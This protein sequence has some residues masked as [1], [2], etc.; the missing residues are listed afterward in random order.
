MKTINNSK[1]KELR[2]KNGISQ[3]EMAEKLGYSGKSGYSMLETGRVSLSLDKAK[4][5]ADLFNSTIDD[6]FFN[7]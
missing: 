4:I 2:L 5:I 1:L 3:E 7:Q 6:I